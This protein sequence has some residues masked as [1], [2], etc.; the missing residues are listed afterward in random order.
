MKSE[1]LL[2]SICGLVAN[3]LSAE[4]NDRPNILFILADD[5]GYN[6]LGCYGDKPVQTPNL[7]KLADEGLRFTNA[8]V[9]PQSSPTRATQIYNRKK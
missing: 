4:E 5:F 3:F 6:Q 1:I 8:Y 9:M 2:L 7:N